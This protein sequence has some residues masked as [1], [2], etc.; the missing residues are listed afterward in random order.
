MRAQRENGS[1]GHR[2]DSDSRAGRSTT[3]TAAIVL[4]NECTRR[5]HAPQPSD[6]ASDLLSYGRLFTTS[7][8]ITTASD[9]IP[10]PPAPRNHNKTRHAASRVTKV[11]C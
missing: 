9:H 1:A 3:R 4:R 10:P 7:G 5:H 8:M 6:H 2:A 11:M